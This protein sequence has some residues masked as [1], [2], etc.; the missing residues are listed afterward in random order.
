MLALLFCLL[1][2][3]AFSAGQGFPGGDANQLLALHQA[4]VKAH[5]ERDVEAILKDETDDYLVASR[6]EISRPTKADRRK[7][8]GPFLQATHFEV[9]RDEVDPVVRVSDD[10]TL[11]WVVVQIYAKGIQMMSSGQSHPIE[12]TSAWI[13]LYEKRKGRWFRT[14]NVSNFKP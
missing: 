7:R 13:E 6:G 14:G 2:A 12:Y 11:G 9:Y 8:L 3:T 4:V 5:L 1:T 10:G